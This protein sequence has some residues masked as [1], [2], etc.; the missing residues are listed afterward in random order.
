M[1]QILINKKL[2]VTPELRR[3]KKIYKVDFII[4]VFL[5]IILMSVYIY[6]EYDKGK[7]EE[8]SKEILAEMNQAI[9]AGSKEDDT[10]AK[11]NIL[12]VVLNGDQED[13]KKVETTAEDST[14]VAQKT[15]QA[16]TS[17][18]RGYNYSTIARLSIKKININYPVIVG[19]KGTLDEINTLLS[20]SLVKYHG[21]DPNEVGNFCIVGHNWW[22]QRFFGRLD[23][24]TIG[25]TIELTDVAKNRTITY[26][27]YDKY[28]VVPDDNSCTTQLT[29]GKKEVT[30]ITCTRE[31]NSGQRIVL[32]CKEVK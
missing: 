30:L 25:D 5:V 18:F 19:E 11:D 8:A 6:A 32:R 16:P 26:A 23:E 12:T 3:K 15:I 2:Y 7:T 1:N 20:T 17:S 14:Q 21:C 9:V 24:M 22:D 27:V 31:R 28:T 29:G 13:A 4:S 10:I